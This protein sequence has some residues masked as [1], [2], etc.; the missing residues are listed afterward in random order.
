MT[1]NKQ[2]ELAYYKGPAGPVHATPQEFYNELN[3]R[4]GFTLDPCANSENHKCDI[5][6]GPDSPFGID[7]LTESWSGHRVFMNPPY[8]RE[9]AKWIKKAHDEYKAHNITIV[10][11]LP[12]RTDTRYFHDYIYH[13]TKITFIKGRLKFNNAGPAPFPSMLAEWKQRSAT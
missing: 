2:K 9:I 7:G 11:L 10:A 13:K 1:N 12:A 8:G 6:F 4:Y 5:W 3:S